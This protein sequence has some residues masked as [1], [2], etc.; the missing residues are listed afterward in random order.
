MNRK[1]TRREEK[2]K[3]KEKERKGR[4]REDFKC[5]VITVENGGRSISRCKLKDEEMNKKRCGG[6]PADNLES[7]PCTS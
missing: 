4:R 2:D 1:V 3:E 7:T 6:S 5:I